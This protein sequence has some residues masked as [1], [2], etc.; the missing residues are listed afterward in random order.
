ML[1][2]AKSVVLVVFCL[3]SIFEAYPET[4]VKAVVDKTEVLTGEIITYTVIIEGVF[5]D[6][7]II[8]PKFKDFKVVSR[9]QSQNYSFFKKTATTTIELTYSLVAFNPGQ[10]TISPAVVKDQEKE[11]QSEP[12][13]ITVEGKPFKEKQKILPYIQE[14]LPI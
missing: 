8:P 5:S 9:I 4:I 1:K 10:F 12:I 13:A 6:P 3:L 14:G 11:Y 2:L 7:E